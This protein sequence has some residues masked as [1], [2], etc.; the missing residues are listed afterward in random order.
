MTLISYNGRM[1]GKILLMAAEETNFRFI[2]QPTKGMW[3]PWVSFPLNWHTGHVKTWS[4]LRSKSEKPNISGD[5]HDRIVFL[6]KRIP[7]RYR[8]RYYNFQAILFP[9]ILKLLLLHFISFLDIVLVAI[10]YF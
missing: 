2:L 6:L 5:N 7:P 4:S 8:H 10:G 9:G 1:K 3:F